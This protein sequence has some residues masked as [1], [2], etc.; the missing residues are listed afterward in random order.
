VQAKISLIVMIYW[1]IKLETK[2]RREYIYSSNL[3]V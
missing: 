3:R 1:S 2:N